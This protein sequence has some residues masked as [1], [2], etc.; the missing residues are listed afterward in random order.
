MLC[1]MAGSFSIVEEVLVTPRI[2]QGAS[3]FLKYYDER[4]EFNHQVVPEEPDDQDHS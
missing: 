3:T 2:F 1:S 4:K